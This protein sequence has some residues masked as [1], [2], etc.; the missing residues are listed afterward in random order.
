MLNSHSCCRRSTLGNLQILSVCV[1]IPQW[2]LG[3]CFVL[4]SCGVRFLSRKAISLC[5]GFL[6]SML[7]FVFSHIQDVSL[8]DEI[9]PWEVHV[10]VPS[11]FTHE[12]VDTH[13]SGNP[14]DCP[15]LD[16]DPALSRCD[17]R[18]EFVPHYF[19]KYV[20]R[21]NLDLSCFVEESQK[22]VYLFVF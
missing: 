20:N 5:I 21:S 9:N 2:L 8:Q 10:P 17:L 14:S 15:S 3:K 7:C 18:S 22:L 13:I 6:F 19:E 16:E 1:K 4:L 11:S 12:L